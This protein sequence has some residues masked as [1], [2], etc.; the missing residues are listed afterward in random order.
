L[1]LPIIGCEGR[2]NLPI[3]GLNGR[4]FGGSTFAGIVDMWGKFHASD[5]MVFHGLLD[6]LKLSSRGVWGLK[7]LGLKMK[8][9]F[10]ELGVL[11]V[12]GLRHLRLG[13]LLRGFGI[14]HQP[15]LFDAIVT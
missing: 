14:H 13:A 10:L 1:D 8:Q 4:V 6:L 11:F 12:L 15:P 9:L 3:D 5:V 2:L 7:A